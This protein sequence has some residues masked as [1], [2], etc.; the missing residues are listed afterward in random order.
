MQPLRSI[1]LALADRPEVAGV[2]VVSDE[3]LIVESA[4]PP[5]LDPDAVAAHAVTVMR[6]LE[7]L[8][9]AIG[10]GHPRQVVS[11]GANGVVVLHRLP[12]GATLLVLAAPDGDLGTLLHDLRRHAPALEQLI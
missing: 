6:H 10:Q 3:G 12:G 7:S 2:A 4:L 5:A 1:L 8:G 9:G 11:E